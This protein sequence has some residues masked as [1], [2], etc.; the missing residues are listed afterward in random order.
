MILDN[1][2]SISSRGGGPL[3]TNNHAKTAKDPMN[4]N[5]N[6]TMEYNSMVMNP[7]KNSTYQ[8]LYASIEQN[9]YLNTD[10]YATNETANLMSQDLSHI[11]SLSD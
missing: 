4:P 8:Q 5:F 6:H 7:A 1:N 9:Q 10:F 2:T 11:L 3:S